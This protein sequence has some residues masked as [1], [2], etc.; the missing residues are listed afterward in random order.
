MKK[1]ILILL[2]LSAFTGFSQSITV[3]TTTYTIDQLV[4][5][6]LIDSPCTAGTN[7]TSR[8]GTTFGSTNGIGYFENFNPNF[9]FTKGVVLTTGD[10]SKSPSPNN[11]I[12]VDGNAA[13][14]G[15]SDLEA[16]LLSQSGVT[17]QSVNA[18]VLEFDFIPRSPNF[19]FNFLFASEEYGTSQCNF[20]DAFAF[21]LKDNSVGGY[22]N[23]AVLP[24]PA[25]PNTPISVATIRDNLYNTACPSANKTFFGAFNTAGFGPAIN[26]NG[27]TI[28]MTANAVGLDVTHTYHIKI[29]IADGGNNS[30]YDSAIFLEGNTFNIGQNVL[31]PDIS[32]VCPNS[33]L[34]TLT[35]G[36]LAAGTTF[37]WSEGT[38]VLPTQTAATLNLNNLPTLTPGIHTFNLTYTQPGCL[39]ISDDIDVDVNQGLPVNTTIPPI[40]KCDLMLPSYNFDLNKAKTYILNGLNQVSPADDLPAATTLV[41]FHLTQP[42]AVANTNPQLTSFPSAGAQTLWIRITN[43][44]TNCTETRSVELKVVPAPI[45]VSAPLD[46]VEC[47]RNTTDTPIKAYFDLTG[48]IGLMYGT[49]DQTQNIISFHTTSIGATNNT[50]RIGYSGGLLLYPAATVYVRIQNASNDCFVTSSFNLTVTPKAPVDVFLDTTTCTNFILPVLSD[51][52]NMEYWSGTDQTGTQYFAGDVINTT[53]TLVVFNQ[54]GGC[55]NNDIFKVTIV[56]NVYFTAL[57][58]NVSN[59]PVSRCTEFALPALPAGL[60][61]YTAAGGPNGLGTQLLAG[62]LITT[63]G[64]NTIWVYY[65][66]NVGIPCFAEKSFLIKII[67][68]VPLPVYP[69]LFGCNPINLTAPPASVKYYDGPQST[70]TPPTLIANTALISVTKEIWVFKK[71][72]AGATLCTSETS[73]TVFIGAASITP[74]PPVS[75]TFCTPQT[76]PTLAVGEYRDGPNGGSGVAIPDGTAVN[77]TTTFWF[78]VPGQSCTDNISFTY[79]VNLAPLP[80]MDLAPVVC[81]QYVLPTINT[82]PNPAGKYYPSS[83]GVGTPY[84]NNFPITGPGLHTVFFYVVDPISGCFLENQIDITINASP[85]IDARPVVVQP[86]CNQNYFLDDLVN[87]EYYNLQGGP[88]NLSPL[89]AILPPGTEIIGNPRTIWI[90]AAAASASN[91]CFQEYS[92][93]VFTVN[94]SVNPIAD[95]SACDSYSLPAIVGNGDYYTEANGPLGTGSKVILPFSVTTTHTYYIYAENNSRILCSSEDA[96]TVTIN[97]TP[98]ITPIVVSPVCDSYTLPA[99]NTISVTPATSTLRYFKLSGG[100]SIA[101]N[102]EYFPGNPITSTSTVYVWAENGATS[103]IVCNS[104]TPMSITINNTPTF[105]TPASAAYCD[106]DNFQLVATD[107]VGVK[108]Y[109]DIAL[110]QQITVFPYAV[111]ATKTFYLFAESG[112]TPNCPA[113]VTTFT[114]TINVTPTISLTGIDFV[115]EHCDQYTLPSLTVGNYFSDATHLSPITNLTLTQTT[116]VYVYADSAT[117]PN[118]PAAVQ[119]FVITIN[120]TPIVVTPASSTHCDTDNFQL[121]TLSVGNYYQDMAHTQLITLP[122]TVAATKTFYV[123]AESGTT[124]N[125]A[126]PVTSFLVTIIPTPVLVAS[127]I[128]DVYTCNQYTLLPL[129]V[130]NYFTDATHTTPLATTFTQDTHVFVYAEAVLGVNVCPVAADFMVYVYNVDPTPYPPLSTCGSLTLPPL[131]VAGAQY[132]SQANGVGAPI[133]APITASQTVFVYGT[134]ANAPFCTDEASF[135]VTI[136]SSATAYTNL[137]TPTQ[138][139]ICGTVTGDSTGFDLDSLTPT[140]MDTQSTIAFSLTYYPTA[141]DATNNTNAIVTDNGPLTDTTLGSVVVKVASV[142]S[143]NCADM[144]PITITIVPLPA[145]APLTGTIC[146]DSLTGVV[147]LLP[148]TIDSSYSDLLYTFKWTD[149][150]GTVVNTQSTLDLTTNPTLVS[151]V[152]T[153]EITSI[154]P[155]SGCASAP[156]SVTLIDSAKPASVTIDPIQ[157]TANWFSDSQTVTVNAVPYIGSGTNFLYSLDGNTPQTSNVFTN[158]TSGPHEITVSDANGCGATPLPVDIKLIK[159][160][161]AFTP[162]GDGINDYWNVTNMASAPDTRIYIYDRYGKLM[163]QIVTYGLGWDGTLNGQPLPAADYWFTVYYTEHGVEKEYKSNISL[164]R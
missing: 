65:E 72:G 95:V 88:T 19:S 13:W 20:S 49:Q 91:P 159:A 114:I 69:N 39:P 97:K 148:S 51:P 127:E 79:T 102:V 38:T 149:S 40:L 87:G 156:I 78:Y 35:S 131:T 153:L 115:N 12:L 23:L 121:P 61:Y 81:D 25:P 4:N 158:V 41:S 43:T 125:C 24:T 9:P 86:I 74:P 99:F 138:T 47:A 101:G 64:N 142:T 58:G 29:V 34:P 10:A 103:T 129:T 76:L 111:L 143:A 112:T 83:G 135:P 134:S 32:G 44:I 163:K 27:Q 150:T 120:Q 59:Y 8:T 30:G 151:G 54:I 119:D 133:T 139:T 18:T 17:I 98:I 45:V 145:H 2:F 85:L 46:L 33:T 152:Y 106:V 42:D 3:N 75:Q 37:V 90:Y 105:V 136:Y 26:F 53:K 1:G 123:Y 116:H 21:L 70:T 155:T 6:V 109:K 96:F 132:Y 157:D 28:S 48:N 108:V 7:V 50:S 22:T 92:I 94:T 82:A 118:C 124:P 107:F 55:K 52:V 14:L 93:D 160:P 161:M 77:A 63:P 62:A 126:S 130:G 67:P 84:P 162:N 137:L 140:I 113:A 11:S 147:S 56:N 68:F 36:N 73:F 89:Q 117:T 5:S 141:L 80:V 15:D 110:T 16:I 128:V 144:K 146:I 100:P 164:I 66:N 122:Y 57:L 60:S 104:E 71:T 31:G 154:L